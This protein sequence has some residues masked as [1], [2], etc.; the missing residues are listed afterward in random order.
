MTDRT[1]HNSYTM[2]RSLSPPMP[3]YEPPSATS[4]S[5]RQG[6]GNGQGS[7]NAMPVK[8]E[9]WRPGQ[10]SS[11]SGPSHT[12]SAGTASHHDL[13][14][15][16]GP[17]DQNR[18]SG[19][20]TTSQNSWG[21]ERRS[22]S[23]VSR[24]DGSP[25]SSR[26]YDRDK[27]GRRDRDADRDRDSDGNRY[28]E[29]DREKDGDTSRGRNRQGGQ[30]HGHG[31][32][33]VHVQSG[34]KK[35]TQ[36]RGEERSWAAWNRKID[37]TVRHD[38]QDHQR[39]DHDRR[40]SR[41]R[42]N[43]SGGGRR[44]SPA[45]KGKD[46]TEDDGRSWAAWKAKIDDTRDKDRRD[47][48][49]RRVDDRKRGGVASS[50]KSDTYRPGGAS[51]N[52]EQRD[53][54][55]DDEVAAPRSPVSSVRARRQ[56]P[57]YG[58]GG[59]GRRRRES[60]DY[61]IGGASR[62][63][64]SQRQGSPVSND[65]KRAPSSPRGPDPKRTRDHSPIEIRRSPS[66]AAERRAST[67]SHSE[68]TQNQ[69]GR[70]DPPSSP[71]RERP[72]SPVSPP[73]IRAVSP[74]YPNTGRRQGLPPQA[75]IFMSGP[76]NGWR[77]DRPPMPPQQRPPSQSSWRTDQPV[78]T[79]QRNGNHYPDPPQAPYGYHADTPNAGRSATNG[80]GHGPTG[81]PPMVYD[82][83]PPIRPSQSQPVPFSQT[84]STSLTP[85][86]PSQT[87]HG[88]P[89]IQ[90]P[91]NGSLGPIKIAF[92]D[93]SP[94]KG[95]FRPISPQKSAVQ[96]LF[97]DQASLSPASQSITPVS[98]EDQPP[99]VSQ[100]AQ[101]RSD[102]YLDRIAAS[103]QLYSQHLS[104]I[105]PYIQAAFDQWFAQGTN[106][107]LPAF[108]VHYF[109]RQ[110]SAMEVNQIGSLLELRRKVTKD[111]EELRLLHS[112][113]RSVGLQEAQDRVD[114]ADLEEADR[115]AVRR[116]DGWGRVDLSPS[117][118]RSSV[119][120]GRS[121]S[122][123]KLGG[124]ANFIPIPLGVTS[125]WTPNV[126]KEVD[127]PP[128]THGSQPRYS[129]I[130]SSITTQQ[131]VNPAS[132]LSSA[133]ST[134]NL[135]S[136]RPEI[137]ETSPAENSAPAPSQPFNPSGE[138]YEKISHV[139]EGTYGKVYKARS[140]ENGKMF[141]LKR[142][143]MEG[144]RDGFPVTAM[145]EIKLLQALRHENVVRLMEMV[146]STGSVY[147]VLEYMDHDLT[148]LLA[149]PTLQLSPA[150]I[151]SLNYQML[152]GL[153]YLHDRGILHR[154]MK[155]SNILLN[156]SGELKLADFGLARMYSKRHRDDYTNR[157]ITLWYRSPELLLG[158]TVYGPEVDMWSAGCIMLELS[159]SKPIFQGSDEIHQ[160]EVIYSIMGTPREE[161]WPEVKEL[162][163]YDLV[164]PKEKV[165]SK[166]RGSFAKRLSPS[167]L[168]L[169]EGLLFFD[170]TKRLSAAAAL[171]TEY[172]TSEEPKMEKPTQLAGMGEHHEM[173]AKQ[174][175]HRRRMEGK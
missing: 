170:P 107:P 172:F 102:V 156:S 148:G 145:R 154:D 125:R 138:M 151:K 96:R 23:P 83:R 120:K 77:N 158:E 171:N 71:P 33:H 84:M 152:S 65:R 40:R 66:P 62:D 14:P 137:S 149:H 9:S 38:D 37:D 70:R 27:D 56:S 117:N 48:D 165:E 110:P 28:R 29:R 26:G 52:K 135:S 131:I 55:K 159:T 12:Q 93:V 122:P 168:D 45:R 11:T 79:G 133:P 61:G 130:N 95:G 121:R 16:N 103:E 153:A 88:T 136:S 99:V 30:G 123:T 127:L 46:K 31:H 82:V 43:R 10:S 60:P 3:S 34:G 13:G 150:N 91:V 64:I 174:D 155:G 15:R 42:G 157:V 58:L 67:S 19:A 21:G 144:E 6:P 175:R 85:L 114:D 35:G 4:A 129:E 90:M 75:E 140:N 108:L 36:G 162:P 50:R 57:D 105:A 101:H 76:A 173:S 74:Q 59:G 118:K 2:P 41:D 51:S 5:L 80:H 81:P 146:V 22:R 141:A 160:L 47:E 20:A 8:R 142:I 68:Q 161:E 104:T 111:Q 32:G 132:S 147:M 124:G 24:R 164:K 92:R 86:P 143:R 98:T 53:D 94:K 63:H 100:S 109:G 115:Q 139:G 106:P 54:E 72:R 73:R 44:Q 17:V 112:Q 119:E 116:N 25:A 69:W 49:W 134:H 166:F 7:A 78:Q 163:W 113:A 18:S 87:T 39:W 169:A 126:K 167:A 97:E 128:A 89:Q 1:P